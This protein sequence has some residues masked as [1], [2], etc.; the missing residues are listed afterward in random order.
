MRDRRKVSLSFLTTFNNL[1][2]P[3]D[4]FSTLDDIRFGLYP[5]LFKECPDFT[6]LVTS[7][8]KFRS[9]SSSTCLEFVLQQKQLIDNRSCL[10]N[11]NNSSNDDI[12]NKKEDNNS[13]NNNNNKSINNINN[14]ITM[15]DDNLVKELTEFRRINSEICTISFKE[16]E[17]K[18]IELNLK[19]KFEDN[20]QRN[21]QCFFPNHFFLSFKNLQELKKEFNINHN[22]NNMNNNNNL[23]K[24]ES[25]SLE[26]VIYDIC[27]HLSNELVDY[28]LINNSD[29]T[30][31]QEL[32]YKSIKDF[33]Q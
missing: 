18:M 29:Q 30:L 16:D 14:N 27:F 32:F 9:I 11:L 10:L 8:P 25:D 3:Q 22:N 12:N 19:L 21:L 20:L 4:F 24:N 23:I 2:I 26:S 13:S 5:R 6:N 33:F 17:T 1:T 7:T 15:L 28:G 31:I